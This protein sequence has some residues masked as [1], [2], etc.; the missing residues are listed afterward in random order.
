MK[1]NNK[2]TMALLVG[3]LISFSANASGDFYWLGRDC[4]SMTNELVQLAKI[5]P[6]DACSGDLL[7][8]ASYIDAARLRIEQGNSD[9]AYSSIRYGEIELKAI[10]RYRSYCTY[11][12][13][14]VKPILSKVISL[15]S[16]IND[17]NVA[18]Q[19]R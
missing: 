4:E 15:A 18:I 3:S 7:V 17:L 19:Q 16:K 9:R 1:K 11:F 14:Q 8:A 13:N 2:K 10:S 5:K 6:D 12:V